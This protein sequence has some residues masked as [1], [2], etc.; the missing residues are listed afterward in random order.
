MQNTQPFLDEDMAN[1]NIKAFNNTETVSGSPRFS[2]T[3][4]P[5]LSAPAAPP[6]SASPLEAEPGQSSAGASGHCHLNNI[7]LQ[8]D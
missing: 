8:V 2:A 4:R 3:P 6:S 1:D 5:L 7:L